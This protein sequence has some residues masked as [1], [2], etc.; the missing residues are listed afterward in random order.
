VPFLNFFPYNKF[1]ALRVLE[2]E[3]GFKPYPYKHYESIFTRFYQGYILPVKFNVDK[4]KLHFS[5]L[6]VSGQM[7]R[8]QDLEGLRGVAYPTEKMLE[9]DKQY[10]LKKMEW[11]ETQLD[12]YLKRQEKPHSDYPTEKNLWVS[13]YNVYSKS[14]K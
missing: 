6:I 3:Y 8:E 5:T 13:F 4:R 7:T 11:S 1:E 12:D 2:E 14:K 10:F 9:A